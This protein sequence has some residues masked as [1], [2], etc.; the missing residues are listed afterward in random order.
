MRVTNE[1]KTDTVA[2][3]HRSMNARLRRSPGDG[4]SAC[5]GGTGSSIGSTVTGGGYTSR[6][7]RPGA[8]ARGMA[9]TPHA[10]VSPEPAHHPPGV[11][12][13]A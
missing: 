11:R 12:R 2:A 7:F 6:D 1:P 9:Y 8:P 13:A 3:L 10:S 5:V 4:S